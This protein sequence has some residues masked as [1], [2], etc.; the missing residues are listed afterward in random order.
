M[1]CWA[2]RESVV[3][4]TLVYSNLGMYF[5]PVVEKGP[6]YVV[7]ADPAREQGIDTYGGTV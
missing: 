2:D 7:V 5:A 1:A 4:A 3:S 6:L